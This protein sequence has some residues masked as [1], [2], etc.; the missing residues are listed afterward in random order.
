MRESAGPR[1]GTLNAILCGRRV[2]NTGKH[3]PENPGGRN[4]YRQGTMAD[5]PA[6]EHAHPGS[7]PPPR[8]LA[9]IVLTI[10]CATL[11]GVAVSWIHGALLPVWLGT[12]VLVFWLLRRPSREWS[13]IVLVCWLANVAAA[14]AIGRGMPRS[15]LL[16]TV[17]LIQALLVATP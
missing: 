6:V 11:A 13:T 5:L 9:T 2:R 12:A 14:M 1:P 16:P 4:R 7:S 3:L 10:F 8:V 17:N 15:I